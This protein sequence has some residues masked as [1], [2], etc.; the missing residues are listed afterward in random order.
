[1]VENSRILLT[2]I[3]V[4]G[5]NRPD[6]LKRS[7]D[8]LRDQQRQIYISI[9]GPRNPT[10]SIAVERC[11]QIV[12]EFKKNHQR[13]S[14][15]FQFHTEN[16]GCKAGT[17]SGINWAFCSEDRLIILED[18][19]DFGIEFLKYCDEGLLAFAGSDQIWH[20]SGWTP[21]HNLRAHPQIY[22]TRYP[23]V[24][25]WATWRDRWEQ[26][27]ADLISWKGQLAS[28]LKTNHE[29]K[30]PREFDSYWGE[31]F[32]QVFQKKL[33]T[34]DVQWLFSMWKNG[35]FAISPGLPLT[36]NIGFGSRASHTKELPIDMY[37]KQRDALM[38]DFETFTHDWTYE[39]K[40]VETTFRWDR[41]HE[42]TVFFMKYDPINLRYAV[43]MVLKACNLE[44]LARKIYREFFK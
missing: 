4:L 33:D 27:D 43:K 13:G 42:E 11:Q 26:Y 17:I 18:D 6:L 44:K 35:G 7:L 32:Q 3:L 1:M 9:D 39:M 10:D 5:F 20:L 34:W 15:A 37:K 22:E 14:V 24:W 19:I 16:L 21:L 2:P 30:V 12:L 31:L 25:G 38:S 41:Y 23:H 36:K 40:Y 8:K 28:K 29:F